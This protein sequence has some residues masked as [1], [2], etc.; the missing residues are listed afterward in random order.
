LSPWLQRLVRPFRRAIF[1]RATFVLFG[2]ERFVATAATR[3]MP[4][5]VGMRPELKVLIFCMFAT[6]SG[7]SSTLRNRC[8]S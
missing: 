3:T 5:A 8:S 6:D 1:V 7:V 4:N 2:V